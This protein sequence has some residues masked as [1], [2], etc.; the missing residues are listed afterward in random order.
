MPIQPRT[1][2]DIYSSIQSTLVSTISK[3]T[4]FV[5]GSFN[6]AFISAYSEQVR[7]AEIKALAAEF[8]GTV[9]YAGKELTE[10]DLAREGIT[11]VSPEE[12]NPYMEDR[13]L[14]LL[15]GNFSVER[16]P[17]L[18][19]T[20]TVEIEVSTPDTT[21]SEGFEVATQ[22]DSDGNLNRYY[23]DPDGDGEVD[24]SSDVTVTPDSG[25][26]LT[27]DVVA[28]DIGTEYNTGSGTITYV[29]NP[30]PGI[31]SVTNIES[32]QNGEEEQDNESLREDVKSALFDSAGGGTES[33]MIGYIENNASTKVTVGGVEE[34]FDSSRDSVDV[35]IDGGNDVEMRQLID[36]SRPVGVQHKL[37]R[38]SSIKI[39]SLTYAVGDDLK[40]TSIR[41]TI[42]GF[43]ESLSV[44]ESFYWSSLLQRVMT[45]D[46]NI[47]SIPAMN[48][49]I[50]D[51]K[52]D[53]VE[54]DGTQS[55]YALNY[56]PIGNVYD[57][58]HL[59]DTISKSYE[60]MF[61]Q[62]N[63]SSVT[64]SAIINDTARDLADTEYTIEDA[65]GNGN[66]G[67]LTVDSSVTPDDGTTLT[68]SYT[69]NS[70]SFDSVQALDGTTYEQGVDYTTVDSN[71][72]GTID[73]IEWLSGGASP[74]DGERFEMEY[75]PYRSIAG[76]IS[77]DT[78][79]RFGSDKDDIDVRTVLV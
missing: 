46:D 41:D 63:V 22:P 50:N 27:V 58:E 51:I 36:E 67:T 2:D 7:E 6:D 49:S 26:T 11:D 21:V 68:V 45:L 19:A 10:T 62:V 43:L 56:G 53:R 70:G 71:S 54:Y 75:S 3:V 60:L 72:D 65:T 33:G 66:L 55:V 64:V 9:D 48:M 16:F 32:F 29:P 13:H 57:E 38:P 44:G 20:G 34:Y 37:V 69:H 79:E 77:A 59:V 76:D 31:Q 1:S 8:A 24:R 28:A 18:P 40:A 5:S 61:D 78:L 47:Q 42:S 52:K 74:N 15:A 12:I 39:G 30:K 23:V 25:T 73:S 35:I 17:G 14:D 4:N